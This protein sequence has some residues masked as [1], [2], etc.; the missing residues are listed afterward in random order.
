M[1]KKKGKKFSAPINTTYPKA[2][3][4]DAAG[5]NTKALRDF[6]MDNKK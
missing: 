5:L 2:N 4:D 6:S 1:S 3:T